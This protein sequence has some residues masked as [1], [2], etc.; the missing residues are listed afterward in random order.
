MSEPLV[1][2]HRTGEI[3][4]DR[5]RVMG[6]LN[7]TPDSFSDGGRFIDPDAAVRRGLEMVEEGTDIVDVGGESTR[8][9][10]DP[11]PEDEEWKRVSPVIQGLA[12]KLS[13]P[14][15][16]DTRKPDV[17]RKAIRAGASIVND[18]TALQDR[19]MAPVV[20]NSGAGVILM[21]IRGEPKTMQDRPSYGDVIQEV[22]A[23]LEERIR[24]AVSDGIDREAIAVDPGIGFGKE[25]S[26]SLALLRHLD[27]LT[28]LGRPIVV[29]VSRKSFLKR[30]GAGDEASDRLAGSLAAATL[31]VARGAHVI[32][33]HDVFETVRAM[34]VADALLRG[35]ES[36]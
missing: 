7:V 22:R 33:A 23:F 34:R 29:G 11:V 3:V 13:V 27:T 19:E 30:L 1:W 24:A 21:H 6:I 25:S 10:S 31:A 36:L 18:V 9:G 4:L 16:I 17:A 14:I 8:P 20:A 32:R 26:H 12:G 15:S 5:T 2:R 28:A 35:S